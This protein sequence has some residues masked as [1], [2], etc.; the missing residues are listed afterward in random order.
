MKKIILILI[1]FLSLFANSQVLKGTISEDY[2]PNGFFGSW[3]VISKLSDTNNP[4][5]FNFESRDVWTLSGYGNIL[6]LEN[7]ESGAV[8]Q[9]QIKDKNKDGKTLK[10][11][12]EKTVKEGNKKIIYKETVE[13]VLEGNNFSG[14]DNFIVERYDAN[15]K[16]IRKDSANYI[17]KGVKISG[18]NPS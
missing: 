12:R 7:I 5:V 6:T 10:F 16:L 18:D 4:E 1:C 3:G 11:S 15:N 14:R 2:I 13:F 17:V 9:I 8:S